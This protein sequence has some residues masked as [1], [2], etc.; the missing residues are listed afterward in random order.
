MVECIAG[1]RQARVTALN[2]N[3]AASPF[4]RPASIIRRD[5]SLVD[6]ARVRTSRSG[7]ERL[8]QSTQRH[9]QASATLPQASARSDM[10]PSGSRRDRMGVD[11]VRTTSTQGDGVD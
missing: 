2:M 4:L 1:R 5:E 6:A 9:R 8:R 3:I 7:A 11:A 10:E